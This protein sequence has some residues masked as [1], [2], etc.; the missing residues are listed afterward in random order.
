MPAAVI[1]DVEYFAVRPHAID[2][3]LVGYPSGATMSFGIN[4][5]IVVTTD[6]RGAFH[7]EIENPD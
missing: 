5:K 7:I 3:K 2:F 6:D 4:Q 1:T